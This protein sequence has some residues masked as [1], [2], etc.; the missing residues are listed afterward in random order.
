M[1]TCKIFA[2]PGIEKK[3]AAHVRQDQR[4]K[5]RQTAIANSCQLGA[6]IVLNPESQIAFQR[7]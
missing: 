6:E 4:G 1:L 5:W 2:P 3:L 7:C